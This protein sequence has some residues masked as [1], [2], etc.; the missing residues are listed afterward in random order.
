MRH[1][2]LTLVALASSA[3]A[4]RAQLPE[5]VFESN[6]VKIHYVITGTGSPVIL[7]H[8]FAASSDVW[9]DVMRD[10]ARDHQ[11]IAPDARGHGNSDKPHDP[12]QY[13]VEMAKD[14]PVAGGEATSSSGTLESSTITTPRQTL[15][16]NDSQTGLLEPSEVRRVGGGELRIAADGRG[17]RHAVD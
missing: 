16:R 4:A 9:G 8:P 2:I 15:L 7:L 13:G 3:V 14:H 11:V 12:K 1:S 10:L 6:G 5:A 17:R